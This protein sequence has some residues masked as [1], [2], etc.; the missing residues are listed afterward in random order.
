LRPS[1]FRIN[2]DSAYR[3]SHHRHGHR[4]IHRGL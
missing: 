1:A 3:Q 4:R 2:W